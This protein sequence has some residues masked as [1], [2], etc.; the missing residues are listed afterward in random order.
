ML[1]G[2][3]EILPEELTFLKRALYPGSRR[4][5]DGSVSWRRGDEN[6]RLD[7]ARKKVVPTQVFRAAVWRATA[8]LTEE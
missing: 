2:T 6:V 1:D 5:I 8:L 4:E 7:S 3:A